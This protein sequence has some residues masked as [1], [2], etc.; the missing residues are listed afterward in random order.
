[1][2]FTR[3]GQGFKKSLFPPQI[4]KAMKLVAVNL[5]WNKKEICYSCRY[6]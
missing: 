5:S 6:K 3:M 4:I 1:M 2:H